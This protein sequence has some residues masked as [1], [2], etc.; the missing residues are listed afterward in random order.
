[1]CP[2]CRQNAPIVYRGVVPHCTACGAVRVPLSGSSVNLAGKPAKIGGTLTGAAGAAVLFVGA[3]LSLGFG[4]LFSLI[5]TTAGLAIGLTMGVL[6]LVMAFSLFFGGR[7][8]WKQ[9][10]A[11]KSQTKEQA[12][13]ALAHVRGGI[14]RAREAAEALNLPEGMAD[15]ELLA[16]ARTQPERVTLELDDSGDIYY[17]FPAIAPP[18][19]VPAWE[20]PRA[21]VAE[22]APPEAEEPVEEPEKRAVRYARN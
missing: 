11:E 8:L 9:G 5:S 1:M 19:R 21:R 7:L 17:R 4:F 12:I 16:L 3:I 18:M 10:E 20:G 14:L 22:P 6:T 2:H 13:F 15:A